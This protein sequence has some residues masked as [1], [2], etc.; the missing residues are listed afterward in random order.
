MSTSIE[1]GKWCVAIVGWLWMTASQ[2]DIK[3]TVFGRLSAKIWAL[4]TQ[5]WCQ[6]CWM[7]IRKKTICECVMTSSSVFKRTQAF[8]LETSL[9]LRHGFL[10]RLGSQALENSAEVFNLLEAEESK[11][12]S[13]WSRFFYVR[14]IISNMYLPQGL[15]MNQQFYKENLRRLLRSMGEKRRKLWLL[16]KSWLLYNDNAP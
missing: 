14:N 5:K 1:L 3:R 10:L 7:M 11:I 8:F 16:Y 2:L 12:N 13:Y 4:S 9:V 6:D 15:V